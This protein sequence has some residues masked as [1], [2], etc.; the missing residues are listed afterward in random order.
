MNSMETDL[1]VSICVLTYNSSE[2]IIETLD[3]I[4]NQNYQ[5]IELIISDD[6]SFDNTVIL[7]TQWINLNRDRFVRVEL[8]ESLQN[9]GVTKNCNKAVR[10]CCGE[11]VKPLGGDDALHFD[12]ISKYVDYIRNNPD[13]QIFHSGLLMYKEKFDAECFIH[14]WGYCN[15]P[16]YSS[17]ISSNQQYKFCL[18]GCFV[19][20]PAIV[21]KKT[22]YVTVGYYDEEIRDVEDWPFYLKVTKLGIKIYYLNEYPIKYRVRAISLFNEKRV[23]KLFN[24]RYI[25]EKKIYQ[26]YIYPYIGWYTKLLLVYQYC[27]KRTFDRFELNKNTFWSK[28]LYRIL[29][30]P[31]YYLMFLS[32]K[33][34]KLDRIETVSNPSLI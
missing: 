2:Y 34:K 1:L 4:K 16:M 32:L 19:N 10:A 28:N 11:W 20:T 29:T 8:I 13:M 27:I 31:F 12:C 9:Q 14:G 26:K 30:I 33:M 6:C 5:N 7:C 22:L 3:S 17:N 21:V 23:D 24:Q 25:R 18:Y 15:H